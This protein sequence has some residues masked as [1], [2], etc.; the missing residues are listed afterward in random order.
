M[1]SIV[2]RSNA[3][4]GLVL[5]VGLGTL[6]T[7]L[8]AW[9]SDDLTRSV[10]YCLIA[11][12]AS[13]M[14]VSLPGVT[15]T[16]SMNF[17]FNLIGIAELSRSEALLLAALGVVVQC[18]LHARTRPKLV[19]IL[20][21]VASISMALAPAYDLYRGSLLH[22]GALEVPLR[23]SVSAAVL[24]FVNTF[25]VAVVIALTEKK[26][27]LQVWKESYLWSFPNYFVGAAVAYLIT[28]TSRTLG[29]QSAL[30]ILPVLYLLFRWHGLYV[31]RVEEARQR[32]DEQRVHAEEVA[33]LHWRTI[34]VL[35]LAIECKDQTTH[36]HLERVQVYAL[37]VGKELRPQ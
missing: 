3:Y 29:W 14:K 10:V 8:A 33:S 35:A 31:S 34:E 30:M 26:S 4:I 25:S 19:Q 9:H 17:V 13:G 27:V 21:S 18:V 22:T 24:F 2:T 28:M 36:D 37:E 1:K 11:L 32:S 7:G 15:G 6:A 16:M 20:F 5:I 12:V 23:L